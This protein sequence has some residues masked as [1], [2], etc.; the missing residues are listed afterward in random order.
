MSA[1]GTAIEMPA[2]GGGSAVGDGAEHTQVLRRQPGAMGLDEACPVLANDV[3]HFE[4]WPRHR[5]WSRRERR[6]VS[7]AETGI[8][9][10]GFVTACKCRRDRCRYT[11]VCDKSA[12][13]T[14][15]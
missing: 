15:S 14:R 12:W 1:R 5:F 8:V 6:A 13:P 2:Q 9:S 7:G 4:G 11:V 3:G 10:S